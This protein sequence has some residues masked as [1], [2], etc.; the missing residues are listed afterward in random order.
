M[1]HG[2]YNFWIAW[3]FLLV[4][5]ILNSGCITQRKCNERYPPSVSDSTYVRD[6]FIMIVDTVVVPGETV[7]IR[8]TVPCPELN[9]SKT[10][11]KNH[12][13]AK[14][15]IKNGKIDF[16]CKA[17]SL[18]ALLNTIRKE[19]VTTRTRSS[20]SKPVIELKSYWYDVYFFRPFSILALL[21]LAG[22]YLFNKIFPRG[23]FR[24]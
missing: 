3:A 15:V 13:T 6:T 17:D 9:F 22:L 23:W 14:V 12:V 1:R 11:K 4:L 8:D 20:V 18:E 2:K 21:I 16:E 7:T 19:R 24:D 10:V 5:I